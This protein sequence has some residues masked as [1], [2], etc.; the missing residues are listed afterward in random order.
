M[1]SRRR[2]LSLAAAPVAALP[3]MAAPEAPSAQGPA[4]AASI[5]LDGDWLFRLDPQNSGIAEAWPQPDRTANGW[6]TVSVPHTWQTEPG[7]EE[8]MGVAWYRRTFEA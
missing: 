2:F 5:P 4:Q 6:R 8:Y 7:N 3:S 1:P